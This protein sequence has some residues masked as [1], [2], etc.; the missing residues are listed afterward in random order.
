MADFKKLKPIIRKWEGGYSNNPNDSGG[1]TMWGVTKST[2]DSY[3]KKKGLPTRSVKLI[4]ES[5]WNEIFKTLYWDRAKADKIENQSLANLI[6][7]CVWGSGGG[8]IKNIQ[9]TIGAEADGIIGSK[10]LKILNDNPKCCFCKIWEARKTY[11]N[12][13]ALYNPKNKTFLKGWLNRLN[14]YQYSE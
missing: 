11:F 7:D 9:R 13:I 12:N 8:Y 6:V 10:T 3:R 2:Y 4:T 1:E 14:D 5:E